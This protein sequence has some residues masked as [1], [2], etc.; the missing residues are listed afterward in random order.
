MVGYT[1]NTHGKSSMSEELLPSSLVIRGIPQHF[2]VGEIINTE[3]LLACN[4]T[5]G[6][7][8]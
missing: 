6:G 3:G 5:P 7:A 4:K 1:G 2:P 8:E